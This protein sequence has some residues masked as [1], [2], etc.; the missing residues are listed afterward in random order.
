MGAWSRVGHGRRPE[1]AAGS[2]PHRAGRR[3]DRR[4]HGSGPDPAAH[5]RQVSAA[6]CWPAHHGRP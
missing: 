1:H 3:P 6:G 2:G 4:A 5:P